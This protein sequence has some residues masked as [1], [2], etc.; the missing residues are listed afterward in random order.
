MNSLFLPFAIS[1]Y[2]LNALAAVVDRRLLKSSIPDPLTFAFYTGITSIG[3]VVFVPLIL[4]LGNIRINSYM[5]SLRLTEVA[6]LSGVF[7]ILAFYFIYTAIKEFDVTRAVPLTFGVVFPM[8]TPL[9]AF[10]F[11]KELL[12]QTETFAYLCFLLG[13]IVIAIDMKN[14]KEIVSKRLLML[15]LA[16]GTT[17]AIAT[18]LQDYVLSRSDFWT[19]VI[20]TRLGAVVAALLILFTPLR[21]RIRRD[22]KTIS[23]A[24]AGIFFGNK[25]IGASGLLLFNAAQR[26]GSVNIAS[27]LKGSEF[28]FVFFL[29]YI[30]QLF[31]GTRAERAEFH[32]A[33]GKNMVGVVL[34]T[35]GLYILHAA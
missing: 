26:A 11:S 3:V 19:A 28:F 29:T 25:I 14:S 13:G 5:L 6:L 24:S 7:L 1:A 33:W 23:G 30:Y 2:F 10:L 15:A 18:V 8:M 17:F 31:R 22:Q 4:F 16:G 27:A 20:W 12:S 32:R 9:F 34:I 35:V 21:A